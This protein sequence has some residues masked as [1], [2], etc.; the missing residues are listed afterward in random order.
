MELLGG[1]GFRRALDMGQSVHVMVA[2]LVAVVLPLLCPRLQLPD[3][4]CRLLLVDDGQ[5]AG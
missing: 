5:A 3:A 4:E 1:S 2:V